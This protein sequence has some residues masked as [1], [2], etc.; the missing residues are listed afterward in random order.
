MTL[1]GDLIT[2][3]FKNQVAEIW[4]VGATLHTY[5]IDDKLIV[6]PGNVT[7][8]FHDVYKGSHGNVLAPWP[9]RVANGAYSF[10]G[11]PLQLPINEVARGHASHGFVRSHE[12]DISKQ[13]NDRVKLSKRFYPQLG[14]PFIFDLSLTYSL[15]EFGLT[16]SATARNT[17][18]TAM[19][20]GIGFHPYFASTD[21]DTLVVPA[22]SYDEVN[23]VQIPVGSPKTVTGTSLDL[24]RG[25]KIADIDLDTPYTDLMRNDQGHCV[26]SLGDKTIWMD[27]AYE[28][29]MVYTGTKPASVAIEPMSCAPDAFNN[30]RGLRLLD[31]GQEFS[32]SWGV[33]T[34]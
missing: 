3:S 8:D 6:E 9:N 2:L 25:A 22:R 5:T 21:Q 15:D 34:R 10:E 28:Y 31:P 23:E 4:S 27:G 32:G 14:F 12:F 26:V 17:G 11:K 13:S 24:A 20:F 30:G 16:V 18:E 1:L 7:A 33:T 19:P 29:A